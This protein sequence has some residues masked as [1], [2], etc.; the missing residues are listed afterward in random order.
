M[1][2][3]VYPLAR[4]E[5]LRGGLS[6][7]SSN[8]KAVLVDLG[9]YTYSASHEFLSDVPS[10][11]RVATSGN[12]ASK[13]DTGGVADADDV[14]F[15]ALT[16]GGGSADIIEAVILYIDT[17]SAATSRLLVFIDTAAGLPVTPTG[18]DHTIRWNASGIFQV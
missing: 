4:R 16:G 1:A 5:C 10:G 13:T 9:Q 11:A 3:V 6:F 7:T 12:L 2:N 18:G 14:T 17:G 8:I 15:V